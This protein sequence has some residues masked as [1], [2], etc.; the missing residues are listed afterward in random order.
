[1]IKPAKRTY[2]EAKTPSVYA[3]QEEES[4]IFVSNLFWES[5]SSLEVTLTADEESHSGNKRTVNGGDESIVY[6]C[7]AENAVL[8]GIGNM[9]NVS[10]HFAGCAQKKVEEPIKSHFLGC[11]R[12][13]VQF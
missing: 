13:C 2:P 12:I 10:G 4:V 5:S 8:N 9:K 1:M 7:I 3:K 11:G 6:S